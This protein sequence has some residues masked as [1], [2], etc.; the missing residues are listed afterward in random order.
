MA[1]IPDLVERR[2]RFIQRQIALDKSAVNVKFTGKRPEGSGPA[3]RHGMPKLP[4]GQHEVRNWPVLDLG[5]QP[6]VSLDTWKLEIDVR[7][8]RVRL[9]ASAGVAVFPD[10]GR[11]YDA[12]LAAAD[13]RMYRDKAERRGAGVT[14]RSPV[15][16]EFLA[17]DAYES[18]DP[19]PVASH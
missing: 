1:D 11:T 14:L 2:Q 9:G 17:S 16:S 8:A 4:V 10:N 12:L 19:V 13:H 15:P 3:N 7:G 18:E 6:E 5:E